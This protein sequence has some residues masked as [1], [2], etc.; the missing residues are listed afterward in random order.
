MEQ[1]PFDIVKILKNN[2]LVNRARITHKSTNKMYNI[3]KVRAS[4]REIDNASNQ[5]IAKVIFNRGSLFIARS[6]TLGSRGLV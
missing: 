4:E 2:N 3:S 1:C 5:L 6:L